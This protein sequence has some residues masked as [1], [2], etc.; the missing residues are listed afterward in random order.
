MKE[1]SHLPLS[2][3]QENHID[4]IDGKLLVK[5]SQDITPTFFTTL[6]WVGQQQYFKFLSAI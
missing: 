2:V 1:Q 6:S 3:K 5:S 4:N